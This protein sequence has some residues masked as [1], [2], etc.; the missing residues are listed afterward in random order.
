MLVTPSF[1][2]QLTF[3]LNYI[4]GHTDQ[5]EAAALMTAPALSVRYVWIIMYSNH[6][7]V[8]DIMVASTVRVKLIE[9]FLSGR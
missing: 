5:S 1:S 6:G 8:D 9:G 3:K 7:P 4:G 2:Q